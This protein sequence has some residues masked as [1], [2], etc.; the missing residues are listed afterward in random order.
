MT[1]IK[2]YIDKG[3][4]LLFPEN[5][6]C[7]CCGNYIDET[8]TY[9]LCDYC[10]DHMGWNVSEPEERSGMTFLKCLDYGIFERSII[11]DLKYNGKKYMA[12]NIAEIMKDRLELAGIKP[13]LLVPV[14]L[15]KEKERARGFNQAN[16][17]SK[18]LARLIGAE[19]LPDVLIRTRY[20]RP[21][22]GLGPEE[23]AENIKGS[24]AFNEKYDK[25]AKDK[26]LLLIDDFY[27]TGSTALE[28]RKA[29]EPAQAEKIIFIAFA[30]R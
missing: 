29:L 2:E 9:G 25:I 11:F 18:H 6:Y 1:G 21:M 16:L 28:C 14:P 15:N 10:M 20:T 8:R 27:T 5:L 3:L 7:I 13:D 17:I 24:I 26:S 19:N 4:G 23:R 12:R 30:A 22:R